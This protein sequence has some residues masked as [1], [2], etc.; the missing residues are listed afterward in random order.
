M[1]CLVLS[2]S[3]SRRRWRQPP[4]SRLADPTSVSSVSSVSQ[5]A[6]SIHSAPTP[7]ERP[8]NKMTR[9]TMTEISTEGHCC[10][11]NPHNTWALRMLAWYGLRPADG[12]RCCPRRLLGK[13]CV[14]HRNYSHYPYATDQAE[15]LCMR[16]DKN[17]WASMIDHT[18]MW[19]DE[20]G[21]LVY[22]TEP[23]DAT[24][25]SIEAFTA[26]LAAEGIT[27]TVG[28]RSPWCP[29]FTTLLMLRAA[30]HPK[31]KKCH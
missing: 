9:P 5:G 2:C 15:C 25:E 11:G 1:F 13:R 7:Y 31:E 18:R 10:E 24:S 6:F 16:L 21:A 19:R 14:W 12:G 27:V 17:W 30:H 20:T 23:Y 3:D 4:R 28:D 29:P 8:A 26:Q 22:T